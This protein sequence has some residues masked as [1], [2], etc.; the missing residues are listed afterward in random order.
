M[1]RQQVELTFQLLQ[2]KSPSEILAVSTDPNSPAL[3]VMCA[4]MILKAIEEGDVTRFQF[5]LDRAVGKV[6]E[7]V[8]THEERDRREALNAMSDDDIVTLAKERLKEIE[9]GDGEA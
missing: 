9:S 5:L 2:T 1:T 6:R 8:E 3:M 7:Q 4:T